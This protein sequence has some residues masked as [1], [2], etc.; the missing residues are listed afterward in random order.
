MV[1]HYRVN[2]KQH[3]VV[4]FVALMSLAMLSMLCIFSFQE[5]S[6]SAK[7]SHYA[8]LQQQLVN[9]ASEEAKRIQANVNGY[10]CVHE[11]TAINPFDAWPKNNVCAYRLKDM[12]LSFLLERMQTKSC[13]YSVILDPK[14]G[15]LLKQQVTIWRL[16]LR[17][18]NNHHQQY[19]VQKLFTRVNEDGRLCQTEG[20]RIKLGV[21]NQREHVV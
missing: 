2:I 12:S 21:L 7:T 14:N 13:F 1:K 17:A 15:Q 9:I 11:Q 5:A 3:G 10:S 19:L 20:F 18:E 4:L 16:S 8:A 6:L